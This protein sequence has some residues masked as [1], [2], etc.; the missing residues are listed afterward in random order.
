VV[1]ANDSDIIVQGIRA[2]LAPYAERVKVVATAVGDPAILFESL[3][4]P[5]ADVLLIDAFSRAGGGLDA[6]RMVLAN[7]PP[8]RVAVFTESDDLKH[9][10]ATLRLGVRGYL[11]KSMSTE[12]LVTS[13]IRIGRGEMVIDPRLATEAAVLA[14][15]LTVRSTWDGAHLGLSRREAEVLRLLASGLSVTAIAEDMNVGRETI[16]THLQQV[17]R[18][19]GVNDRAGAVAAA[20]REGL[21][22]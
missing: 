17:Y 9:L 19:L 21:G 8:L 5:E 18:K 22:A 14:A 13:L 10:F 11:L 6:A 2:L 3:T 1:V 7:N 4:S 16:R 15:R 12:A 20:W